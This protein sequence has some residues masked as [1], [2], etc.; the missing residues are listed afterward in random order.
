MRPNYV[1]IFDG[2][3]EPGVAYRA[4]ALNILPASMPDTLAAIA[5]VSELV[6]D[7]QAVLDPRAGDKSIGAIRPEYVDA[8][9]N[10]PD[11]ADVIGWQVDYWDLGTQLESLQFQ[12]REL[13]EDDALKFLGLIEHRSVA[14]SPILR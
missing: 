3:A 5:Q 12:T 13:A 14:V 2:G 9:P 11:D 6:E 8:W 10:L 1:R 7:P 4:I